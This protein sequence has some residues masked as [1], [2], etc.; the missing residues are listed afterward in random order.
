MWYK[1]KAEVTSVTNG[2]IQIPISTRHMG[3]EYLRIY[4]ASMVVINHA[5]SIDINASKLHF[6]STVVLYSIVLIAVPLF[7]LLSGAFLITNKKNINSFSFWKHSFKKL[8]P[9]SFIFIVFAFYTETHVIDYFISGKYNFSEFIKEIFKCYSY[10]IAVPLWYICMLPG[11][12]FAVPILAKMWKNVRLSSFFLLALLFFIIAC[13]VEA[14][15]ININ[16]PNPFSAILWLGLFMLGAFIIHIVSN[17]K[18]NPTPYFAIILFLL[19]SISIIRAFILVPYGNNLYESMNNCPLFFPI[20]FAPLIFAIFARWHP[21]SNK[22]IILLS[23]LSFLIYLTHV[24]CQRA[25]R[26]ILFHAGY[27]DQL[28]STLWNNLLYAIC[29]LI[30]SIIAAY[31]IQKSYNTIIFWMVRLCKFLPP[32]CPPS[33]IE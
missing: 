22:Y 30:T 7:V 14:R 24:P 29:S 10:G 15:F 25:I 18:S 1:K 33:K 8:F 17:C 16:L 9:F 23:Q 28:H 21:K 27:I 19:F 32:N 5:W 12:Y 26:A 6:Y 4:A 13:M 20:L 31:I 11:L 2:P 3:L